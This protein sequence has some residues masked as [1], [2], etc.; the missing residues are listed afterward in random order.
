MYIQQNGV[1]QKK[2]QEEEKP[3]RQELATK[4]LAM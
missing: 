2:Q 4:L 1:K 3:R